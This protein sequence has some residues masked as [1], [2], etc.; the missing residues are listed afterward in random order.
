MQNLEWVLIDYV[1]TVVHV[2]LR[3]KRQLYNLEDLWSD[4]R[5][6]TH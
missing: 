1:D 3:D 5:L 4:A 2:F 6:T